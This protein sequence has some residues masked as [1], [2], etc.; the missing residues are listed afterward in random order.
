MSNEPRPFD[1]LNEDSESDTEPSPGDE[2]GEMGHGI[3][4][5][6]ARLPVDDG[7]HWLGRKRRRA[8]VHAECKSVRVTG[9]RNGS[10][11]ALRTLG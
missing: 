7:L 4:H 2:A 8:A 5:G 11:R 6:T 9:L 3:E 1:T 10:A